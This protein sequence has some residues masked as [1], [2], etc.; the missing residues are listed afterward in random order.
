MPIYASL[1]SRFAQQALDRMLIVNRKNFDLVFKA[2]SEC[3]GF[4]PRDFKKLFDDNLSSKN[5][6]KIGVHKFRA[7]EK[8]GLQDG[9]LGIGFYN[10]YKVTN[11]RAPN[12]DFLIKTIEPIPSKL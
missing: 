11:N 8:A 4:S 2:D 3:V 6:V 9:H 10:L 12:C 5:Y 1:E 7:I